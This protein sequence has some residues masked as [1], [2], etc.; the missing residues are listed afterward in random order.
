[1][2]CVCKDRGSP[3][4]DRACIYVQD[5]IELLGVD[6]VKVEQTR[7]R[8]PTTDIVQGLSDDRAEMFIT[9]LKTSIQWALDVYGCCF[10]R[11]DE[12]RQTFS[13]IEYSSDEIAD[14]SDSDLRV[15]QDLRP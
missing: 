15:L 12:R 11:P 2:Y 6:P 1:M 4:T 10:F 5:C 13:D 9:S 14:L 7:A 8:C 3:V